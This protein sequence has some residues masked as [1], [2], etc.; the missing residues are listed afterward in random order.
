MSAPASALLGD[1][2]DVILTPRRKPV[3]HEAAIQRSIID[4]LRW[5]GIMAIHV[6]NEGKRS[7]RAGKQAK[8]DGMRPGWPDLL[9]YG[10]GGR[11][12]LMEVKRPGWRP[13]DLSDNQRAT[14]ARLRELGHTVH[15]VASIDDALTIVRDAG[16]VR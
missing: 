14:H 12:M 4:A 2:D 9:I 7:A 13:S 1:E 8:R 5:R 11:H 6:P 10:P 15:V 3:Q 16:W